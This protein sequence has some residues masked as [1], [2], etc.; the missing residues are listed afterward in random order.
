MKRRPWASNITTGGS[1]GRCEPSDGVWGEAPAL[2]A[3]FALHGLKQGVFKD[4][5]MVFDYIIL[6]NFNT[7]FFYKK[8]KQWLEPGCFLLFLSSFDQNLSL[9]F[10]IDWFLL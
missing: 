9:R 1:G 2:L 7:L 6:T 5:K 8:L 10:L 3:I 4:I